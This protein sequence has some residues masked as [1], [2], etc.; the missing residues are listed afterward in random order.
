ME[1]FGV[2]TKEYGFSFRNDE[3]VLKLIVF[4]VT[5]H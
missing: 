3:D 5:Q 1:R 2:A 4:M